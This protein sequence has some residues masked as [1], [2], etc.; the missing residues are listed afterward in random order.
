MLDGRSVGG[1][2]ISSPLVF[3]SR[4]FQSIASPYAA[5]AIP[6]HFDAPY[7]RHL[8][9]PAIF[10][11][12]GLKMEKIRFLESSIKSP[13]SELCILQDGMN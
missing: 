8:Q 4:T 10:V 13:L 7:F 1:R 11:C 6:A 2:K 9:V 5:D 3:D 12:L